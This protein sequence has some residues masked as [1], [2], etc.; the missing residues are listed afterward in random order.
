MKHIVFQEFQTV[1]TWIKKGQDRFNELKEYIKQVR[2]LDRKIKSATPA[3]V[4]VFKTAKDNHLEEI[5]KLS[6]S[7][8]SQYT[9]FLNNRSKKMATVINEMLDGFKKIRVFNLVR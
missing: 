2:S 6:K 8:E 7:I 5:D 9:K 1:S 3:Q 4:K